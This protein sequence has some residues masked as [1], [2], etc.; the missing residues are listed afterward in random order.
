MSESGVHYFVGEL[1][2]LPSNYSHI[3]NMALDLLEGA[4]RLELRTAQVLPG[5]ASTIWLSSS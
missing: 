3:M 4:P 1:Y 2:E 5:R